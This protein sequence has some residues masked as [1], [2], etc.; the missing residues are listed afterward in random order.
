MKLN[1]RNRL[2]KKDWISN[3][4]NANLKATELNH[5]LKETVA[6]LT[7]EF[8][9]LQKVIDHQDMQAVLSA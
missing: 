3:L 8:A 4:Q 6:A 1:Y 9:D 7:S 2:K 5:K